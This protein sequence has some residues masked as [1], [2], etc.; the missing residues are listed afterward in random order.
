M[1]SSFVK[2]TFLIDSEGNETKDFVASLVIDRSEK[3]NSFSGELLVELSD[4]LTEL[5]LEKRS[6]SSSSS[7]QGKHFSAERADLFMDER[8]CNVELKR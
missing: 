7:R 4:Y 2:K 1:N 3:A 5:K 8:K 6:K